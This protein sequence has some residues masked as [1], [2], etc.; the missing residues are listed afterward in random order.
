MGRKIN[1]N[2]MSGTKTRASTLEKFLRSCETKSKTDYNFVSLNKR[3]Y[4]ITDEGTLKKLYLKSFPTFNSKRCTQLIPKP[5]GLTP[6][7]IDIDL[8]L[9]CETMIPNDIFIELAKKIC[10]QSGLDH[11]DVVITRRVACYF[12]PQNM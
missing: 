3:K 4:K 8:R 5:R 9:S 6:I 12:D 11:V 7:H 1:N 10:E 2:K